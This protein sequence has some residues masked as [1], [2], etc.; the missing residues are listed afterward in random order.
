M[1]IQSFWMGERLTTMEQLCIQS[2][3][4]NGH[5]FDLYAYHHIANV[6]RGARLLDARTILPQS[7]SDRFRY[8]AHTPVAALADVFRYKLLLEHGGVWVDMDVVCLKPSNIELEYCFPLTS[9]SKMLDPDKQFA[10]DSWFMKVPMTCDFIRY[11][12]ETAFTYANREMHWGEIGPVLVAHAVERFDLSKFAREE[13]VFFPVNWNRQSLFIDGSADADAVWERHGSSSLV[14]HLYHS[15][16]A[17]N[18]A[19]KNASFASNSLY[20]RLK[21]KY[22]RLN[23]GSC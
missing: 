17:R 20:E 8:N 11:C 18:G 13:D 6:P 12:Y 21:R 14:M 1:K 22:L 3:L 19:D 4:K 5:E 7:V 2:F 9:G 23:G 10:V 15:M 16:W